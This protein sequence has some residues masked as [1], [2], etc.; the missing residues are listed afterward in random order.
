LDGHPQEW[1]E[2]FVRNNL[3]KGHARFVALE[4]GRVI[5]WCDI[6]PSTR[7]GFEVEGRKRRTRFLDGDFQDL[8]IMALLSDPL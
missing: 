2:G 4:E 1:A 3:E 7:H 8:L 5:G 6:L